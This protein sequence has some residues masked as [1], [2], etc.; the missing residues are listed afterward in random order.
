MCVCVYL[1]QKNVKTISLFRD[2]LSSRP[3]CR[4]PKVKGLGTFG[5]YSRAK[6]GEPTW[7]L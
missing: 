1:K 2:E 3:F 4:L 5:E 7:N 6:A